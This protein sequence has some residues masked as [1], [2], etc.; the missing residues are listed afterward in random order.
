MRAK[1]ISIVLITICILLIVGC[2]KNEVENIEQEKSSDETIKIMEDVYVDYINDM[3]LDSQKYI[4][5]IIEIEGMFTIEK[6]DEN[7]DHMYVYRLTE[8]VED[9]HNHDLDNSHNHE[10]TEIVEVK[11]GLEFQYDKKLPREN[12]WIKVTG[13]LVQKNG[14]LII[15]AKSVEILNNRGNEKV[16]S[17][18]Y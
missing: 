3:Y 2:H 17:F 6:D 13:R 7:K 10:E 14:K 1:K 9:S 16:S 11:C 12:D 8:V 4:G 5:K 15:E 18:Y